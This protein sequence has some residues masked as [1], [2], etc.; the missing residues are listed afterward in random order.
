MSDL[1][2]NLGSSDD[3]RPGF[4]CVDLAL[5]DCKTCNPPQQAD[6][7]EQWPWADSTVAEIYAKDVAEHIGSGYRLKKK[8]RTDYGSLGGVIDNVLT[9]VELAPYNGMI[10]FLNE[11]HR[12]L[13]PGGVMELIVPCFP[14]VAPFVDPTHG[15]PIWT[16]GSRY[17]FDERW[18]N[19]R[20]ERGRLGPGM[21][22]TALF[23][24]LPSSRSGVD[25]HPVA[26]APDDPERRKLFLK[27]EAVK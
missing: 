5:P 9:D 4:T 10:H 11:A 2:I 27:L 24:T 16:S 14:G 21:G 23:R 13:Q 20:D 15:W 12:V 17:Y 1:R 7:R 6:L 8:F 19:P 3:H 26:Y 22:I 25:W 18:N